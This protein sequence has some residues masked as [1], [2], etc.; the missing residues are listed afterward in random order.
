MS[1]LGRLSSYLE[2]ITTFTGSLKYT[3]SLKY[4]VP[5]YNQFI[6][7]SPLDPHSNYYSIHDIFPMQTRTLSCL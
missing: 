6:N 3:E 1:M 5:L 4:T 2:P 7:P